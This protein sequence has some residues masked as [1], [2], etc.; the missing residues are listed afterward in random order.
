MENKYFY[1]TTTL[2]YVNADP[3]IGHA[4]E[5]VQADVI[6][7]YH[8]LLGKEVFFN[9][10]ADEHGLKI[11]REAIAQN[12]TPKD[13]CDIYAARFDKLKEDLGLSYNNF[14]RTTDAHHI[15]AAQEF[16]RCC[17]SNGDIYKKIYKV[18]YCVGCELEKTDSELIE[19]KCPL[20]P[21]KELEIIEEEN[22]FFRWSKYQTRLLELYKGNTEFVLPKERFN[23]I[24]SFV[25]NGLQD[26]SIS[27]LKNKMPW[28]VEVPDDPDHIMYVWF[29]ALINYISA[30][31]W[32]D[33]M[34]NFN[35]WWPVFQ[36][37]GKDNLR[38]QAAMFQAMLMS[39]GLPNS[40]QILIHGFITSG[41]QK[42]S[43]SLGNVIN[44]LDLVKKYGTEAVRYYLLAEF[45]TMKDGDFSIEKFEAKYNADLANGLG[46]LIARTLTMAMKLNKLNED[47]K[48]KDIFGIENYWNEY[49]GLMKKLFL[50]EALFTVN[51]LI[52]K[53]DGLIAEVKPWEL[54]KNGDIEKAKEI[55]V[56]ILETI[57]HIG[58]MIKPFLPSIS[59]KIFNALGILEIEK[60]KNLQIAKEWGSVNFRELKKMDIL[61]PRL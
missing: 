4:L 9:T 19:G 42:M 11:Y 39:A 40:K 17:F 24:I 47:E 58:W 12:K 21:N 46:N 3:H 5:Y 29:D 28:G 50:N 52:N 16:W 44:P 25:E 22:Y 49:L 45:P 34:E 53:C 38:Q 60:D 48:M 33:N 15:A 1:I 31:G 27:R 13:F 32:P 8:R 55:L 14:I 23:E 7:R 37:A 59:D 35:K 18:K 43:K 30:I 36:I 26:F 61:F 41:G 10:G 20:H 2:P 51:K 56:M 54:I 6:A 57:R